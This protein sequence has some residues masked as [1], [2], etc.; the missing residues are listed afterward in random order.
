MLLILEGGSITNKNN[1][2]EFKYGHSRCRDDG[3]GISFAISNPKRVKS[4]V[5]R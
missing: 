1:I 3:T 5:S 4:Q 2:T